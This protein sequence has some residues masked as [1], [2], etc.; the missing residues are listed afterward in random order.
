MFTLAVPGMV[1]HGAACLHGG[2][3]HHE[4][5]KE[6]MRGSQRIDGLQRAL[7]LSLYDA[8]QYLHRTLHLQ[9]QSIDSTNSPDTK[10]FVHENIRELSR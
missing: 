1:G 8:L 7:A 3:A 4:L 10:R 6:T 2:A 5:Q 9:W